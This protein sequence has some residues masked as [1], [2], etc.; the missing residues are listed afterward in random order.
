V[1]AQVLAAASEM[2]QAAKVLQSAMDLPGVRS[3]GSKAA[4]PTSSSTLVSLSPAD[5]ASIFTLL[6]SI[7]VKT[8]QLDEAT[9]IIQHAIAEFAGTSEEVKVLVA[10]S[11][12]AIEKG[13]VDQALNMLRS[14]KPEHPQYAAAKAAMADIYMKHRKDKKAYARCYKA[15]VDH[16]PTVQNYLIL[17]EALLNIQEPADA[18]KAF[19]Q[20]IDIDK[21]RGDAALVQKIGKAMTQLHDYDKAIQYYR[22]ALERHPTQQELRQD[23][24]K[25]YVALNLWED[26]IRELEEALRSVVDDGSIKSSKYKVETLQ[27]LAKVHRLKEDSRSSVGTG[28]GAVPRC[29]ECLR[30]ARDLQNELL[31][32]VRLD[33]EDVVKQLRQESRN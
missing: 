18:I 15:I 23:L 5:R 22:A 27:Q 19:Q 30:Q 29:S 16:Q 10:N 32:Q 31:S 11:Q 7:L 21:G 33:D 3:V 4:P 9:K 14:M 13:E 25:L 17:G 26:G 6:V 1:K 24:A 28:Y 20:A 2:D 8:K 12:L